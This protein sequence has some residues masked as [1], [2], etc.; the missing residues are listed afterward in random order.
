MQRRA[1]TVAD[2]TRIP[3]PVE[4]TGDGDGEFSATLQFCLALASG[5]PGSPGAW[6]AIP[7]DVAHVG[8]D[9]WTELVQSDP[10]TYWQNGYWSSDGTVDLVEIEE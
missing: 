5:S 4:I 10:L 6:A 2:G 3:W 9:G 1:C 8:G 7:L